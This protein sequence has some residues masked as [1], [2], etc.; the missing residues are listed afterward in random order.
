AIVGVSVATLG[1][2][3]PEGS[4]VAIGAVLTVLSIP[5][6]PVLV[7]LGYGISSTNPKK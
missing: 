7:K 6:G 5:M 2:V 1:V 4:L 3:L